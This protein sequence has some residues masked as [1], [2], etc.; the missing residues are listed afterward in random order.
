MLSLADTIRRFE[1][2]RPDLDH[3][4]PIDADLGCTAP[5]CTAPTKFQGSKMT[6]KLA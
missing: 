4:H 5:T 6:L 1:L 2:D 3:K